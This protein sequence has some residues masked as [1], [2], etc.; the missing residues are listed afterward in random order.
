MNQHLVYVFLWERKCLHGNR[1]LS[2]AQTVSDVALGFER[3]RDVNSSHNSFP[4]E[5]S[6]IRMDLRKL[7]FIGKT[8]K[9]I[10]DQ[11]FTGRQDFSPAV[12]IISR[13]SDR[14]ACA[15]GGFVT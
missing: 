1:T 9:L 15:R 8:G 10:L 7:G 12:P 14:L 11:R 2:W 4:Q 5:I 3:V 13:R 6:A